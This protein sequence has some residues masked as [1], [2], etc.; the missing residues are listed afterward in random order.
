M[1]LLE[2]LQVHEIVNHLFCGEV[3]EEALHSLKQQAVLSPS[4]LLRN[5]NASVMP[6]LRLP[7]LMKRSE[8]PNIERQD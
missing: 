8:I 1:F 5:H 7:A 3:I 6:A 2:L 4:K